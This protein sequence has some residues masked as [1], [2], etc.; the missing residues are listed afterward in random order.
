MPQR[1][2][3]FHKAL[4]RDVGGKESWSEFM[5]TTY[6]NRLYGNLGVKQASSTGELNSNPYQRGRFYA[7]NDMIERE[8][9]FHP[10]RW[11]P[12]GF[13][14]DLID[15]NNPNEIWD[16]VSGA[17]INQMYYNFSPT[18]HDI[19]T[20]AARFRTNYPAFNTPDYIDL[21]WNHYPILCW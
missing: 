4:Q 12:Y 9:F 10:D 7:A 19:C 5:G 15:P 1:P 14:H 21:I 6:E 3:A 13:Y 20:Y 18:V 11:I 16:R 2:L 8:S 17:T